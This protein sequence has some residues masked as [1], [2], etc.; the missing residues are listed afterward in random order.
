MRDGIVVKGKPN[1][2]CLTINKLGDSPGIVSGTYCC[3][4]AGESKM[5]WKLMAGRVHPLLL[6]VAHSLRRH[7]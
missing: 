6:E 5:C 3:G 2:V 7:C 4:Q 1:L